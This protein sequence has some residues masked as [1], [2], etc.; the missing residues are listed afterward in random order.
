MLRVGTQWQ[1]RCWWLDSYSSESCKKKSQPILFDAQIFHAQAQKWPPLCSPSHAQ[2]RPHFGGRT[3][4]KLVPRNR[5]LL[6]ILCCSS[7]FHLYLLWIN[8]WQ[9]ADGAFVLTRL[10]AT[11]RKWLQT[12]SAFV[13]SF[14]GNLAYSRQFFPNRMWRWNVLSWLWNICYFDA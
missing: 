12:P 8:T 6:F 4:N 2:R 11:T 5:S 14:A 10:F 1:P 7:I 13:I 3:R 9:K